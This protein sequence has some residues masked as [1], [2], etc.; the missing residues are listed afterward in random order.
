MTTIRALFRWLLGKPASL[1]DPLGKAL[2]RFR[3]PDADTLE[4]IRR[5]VAVLR[6]A[7]RRDDAYVERSV[8]DNGV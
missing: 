1:S 7:N 5:L 2:E 4:L 6:P 3:N 8:D